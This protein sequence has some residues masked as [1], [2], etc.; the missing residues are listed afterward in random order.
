MPLI[1]K[2]PKRGFRSRAHLRYQIINLRDLSRVKDNLITP[3][4]LEK[5]RLIKNKNE[6]VKILGEGSINKAITI[7][8]MVLS[9]SAKEKIKLAGGECFPH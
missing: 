1:R 3:E 8:D 9:E 4:V 7:K 5:S 6:P 2:I